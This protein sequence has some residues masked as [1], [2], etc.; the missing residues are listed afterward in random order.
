MNKH[1]KDFHEEGVPKNWMTEIQKALG[2]IQ[3]NPRPL[4]KKTGYCHDFTCEV[5]AIR[6]FHM[7]QIGSKKFQISGN[8][9]IHRLCIV[10]GHVTIADMEG[11]FEIEL[12][13]EGLPLLEVSPPPVPE[14]A[15]KFFQNQISPALLFPQET[16]SEAS[17][18]QKESRYTRYLEILSLIKE[19]NPVFSDLGYSRHQLWMSCMYFMDDPDCIATRDT[20]NNDTILRSAEI[21]GIMD[22]LCELVGDGLNGENVYVQAKEDL[23]QLFKDEENTIELSKKFHSLEHWMAAARYIGGTNGQQSYT[24]IDK[25]NPGDPKCYKISPKNL[26]IQLIWL[27]Q[28]VEQ[29]KETP[30]F[31]PQEVMNVYDSYI[32]GLRAEDFPQ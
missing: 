14:I 32:V 27:Q 9:A 21:D 12:I 16:A 13:Q 2:N 3:F 24:Y 23:V 17:L 20:Q 10:N 30:D 5:N 31:S 11:D 26:L 4:E 15:A 18:E 22:D 7:F 19:K 28:Y 8:G 25:K 1:E 29:Q 6:V